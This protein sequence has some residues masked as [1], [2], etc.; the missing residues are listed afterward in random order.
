MRSYSLVENLYNPYNLEQELLVE[1][2]NADTAKSLLQ[3]VVAGVAEYGV[4]A[5]TLPAAGSGLV[6]GP[7]MDTLVDLM[8][9]AE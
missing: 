4:G 1:G 8:F 9:T 2:F 6:V 5:L 3:W 7:V